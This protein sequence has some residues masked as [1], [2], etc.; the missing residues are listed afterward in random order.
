MA[1]VESV[2]VTKEANFESPPRISRSSEVPPPLKRD[3][4]RRKK[5]RAFDVY[6]DVNHDLSE[7]IVSCVRDL[8]SELYAANYEI[9]ELKIKLV[10]LENE[11]EILRQK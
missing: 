10:D 6:K 11:L 8:E 2:S 5:S 4:L 7:D 3:L 1:C 9:Y